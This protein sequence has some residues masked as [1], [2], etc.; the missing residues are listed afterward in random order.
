MR[1][2]VAEEI[3][4][5]VTLARLRDPDA[6]RAPVLVG[7]GGDRRFGTSRVDAITLFESRPAPGGHVYVPLQRTGLRPLI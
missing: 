1:L 6:L 7:G 5:P 2:F 4:P 3:D